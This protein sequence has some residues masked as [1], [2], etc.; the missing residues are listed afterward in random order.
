MEIKRQLRPV[1]NLRMRRR[2]L[3]E[4][5]TML[6]VALRYGSLTDFSHTVN[7]FKSISDQVRGVPW[8][9]SLAIRRFQR[10]GDRFVKRHS[11]S[12]RKKLSPEQEAIVASHETM[13]SQ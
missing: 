4:K 2:N 12:R 11:G 5:E 13:V 8:T 9:I 3:T 10:N 1:M 7:T 6:L